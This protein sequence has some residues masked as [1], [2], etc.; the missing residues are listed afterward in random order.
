MLK[1]LSRERQKRFCSARI[2][3]AAVRGR[4][5]SKD[6]ERNGSVQL[7]KVLPPHLDKVA[8]GTGLRGNEKLVVKRAEPPFKG[9]G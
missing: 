5:P 3:E 1:V 7:F 9:C 6:W 4:Q 2:C 8:G